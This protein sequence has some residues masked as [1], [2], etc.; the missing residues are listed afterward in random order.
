MQP[1]VPPGYN[2]PMQ[3]QYVPAAYSNQPIQQQ[4]GVIAQQ[5]G[6]G[7]SE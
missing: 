1:Y 6:A 5:P 7:Q 2:P 3:Q 4:P